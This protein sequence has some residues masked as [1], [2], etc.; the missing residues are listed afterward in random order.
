M[1]RFGIPGGEMGG[2]LVGPGH[3]GFGPRAMDPYASDPF[4]VGGPRLPPYYP[5]FSF[6]SFRFLSFAI[7]LPP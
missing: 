3:P 6:L 5:F 4:G 1:F 2:N 7:F